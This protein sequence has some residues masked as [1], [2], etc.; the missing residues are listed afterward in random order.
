MTLTLTVHIDEKEYA[1]GTEEHCKAILRNY[2]QGKG[3]AASEYIDSNTKNKLWVQ[4][5]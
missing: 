1:P 2:L 3:V 5:P 4:L